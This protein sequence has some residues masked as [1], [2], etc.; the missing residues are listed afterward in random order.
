MLRIISIFHYIILLFRY[1]VWPGSVAFPDFTNPETETYWEDMV[2]T[3]HDNIKF[4]GL[5]IDM[6]EP[7]NFIPGSLD[8]CPD[9]N[10]THPPF[11]PGGL[12]SLY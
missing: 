3:F 6:N 7:S 4:D 1:Q 8:G 2:R 5:W 12:A 11:L 9:S 10:L